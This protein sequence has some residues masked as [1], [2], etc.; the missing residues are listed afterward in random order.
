MMLGVMRRSAVDSQQT[1]ELLAHGEIIKIKYFN[2]NHVYQNIDQISYSDF[3]G[4][5]QLVT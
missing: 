3:L 1:S 4:F 2:E 5:F